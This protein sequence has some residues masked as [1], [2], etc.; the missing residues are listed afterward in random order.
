VSCSLEGDGLVDLLK[1]CPVLDVVDVRQPLLLLR[2]ERGWGAFFRPAAF[3][4]STPLGVL[5]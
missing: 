4:S 5:A 2:G 3:A 1:M